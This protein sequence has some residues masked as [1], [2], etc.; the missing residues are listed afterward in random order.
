[1]GGYAPSLPP[2]SS[3]TRLKEEDEDECNPLPGRLP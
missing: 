3:A 1:L 2:K